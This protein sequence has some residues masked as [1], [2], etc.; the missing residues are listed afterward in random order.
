MKKSGNK[1]LGFILAL[2]LLCNSIVPVQAAGRVKITNIPINRVTKIQLDGKGAKEN[3]RLTWKK[4]TARLTINGKT[5]LNKRYFRSIDEWNPPQAEL[6]VT[7]VNT[8]DKNKDL[9][10]AVYNWS[11][12]GT[13]HELIRVTY[14]NGKIYVDPLLKTLKAV[15]SPKINNEYAD[16]SRRG[17]MLNPIESCEGLLKG[18]LI[19]LGNGTV[20]WHICLSSE[21]AGF[22][23]GYITLK[24]KSG[25]LRVN[26]YPSGTITQMSVSGVLKRN[27]TLYS[28]AGSSKRVVT[29]AKGKK[30]KVTGFTFVKKKLYMKVQYG[31]KKGWVSKN[32]LKALRWDGTLHV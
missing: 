18:D 17:Y 32:A 19:V 3:V 15:K 7:D 20:K 30:V 14:K 26:H 25:R 28:S 2:L 12:S 5:V 29:I 16:M 6:I 1:I 11:W 13:Y 4:G 22:F 31:K 24:L 27:I 10:L 8:K 9:F 21:T 23:H